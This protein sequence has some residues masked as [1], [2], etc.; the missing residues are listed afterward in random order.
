MYLLYRQRY[1]KYMFKWQVNNFGNHFVNFFET[2][3]GESLQMSEVAFM[4][5]GVTIN[6]VKYP[7]NFSVYLV[8]TA[9]WLSLTFY[10]ICTYF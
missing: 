2:T 3:S 1:A 10:S 8:K 5:Q 9:V 4:A 6:I 7:Y